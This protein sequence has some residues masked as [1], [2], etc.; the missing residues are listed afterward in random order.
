MG[1]DYYAVCDEANEYVWLDE[2]VAEHS[3]PLSS[4]LTFLLR[5]EGRAVCVLRDGDFV[6][7]ALGRRYVPREA[8]A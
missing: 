8:R 5:H 3:S 4:L 6:D 2:I 7:W 1:V